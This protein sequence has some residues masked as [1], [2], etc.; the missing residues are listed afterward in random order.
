LVA[1]PPK[2]ARKELLVAGE[3]FDAAVVALGTT[4]AATLHA[5]EGNPTGPACIAARAYERQTRLFSI[6]FTTLVFLL[7]AATAGLL[8]Y[9]IYKI[10]KD[11]NVT[12]LV[13]AAGGVVTG[14]AAGFL[15]KYMNRA[16]TLEKQAIAQIEK[17]CGTQA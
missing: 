7:A 3:D 11:V 1:P 8:V 4:D 6:L 10:S 12:D 15:V 9:A 2:T 5:Q 14:A 16:N 13:A 17:Y